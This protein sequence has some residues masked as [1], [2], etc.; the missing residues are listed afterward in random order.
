MTRIR[1]GIVGIGKI[2]R[3]QHIPSLHG[4]DAFEL[5]AG[6]SRLATVEG[7][8][9]FTT[10]EAML[11]GCP[12][13]DAVSICTPPQT[14]FE[15]ARLCLK[16]G[17]HV[18]LEKPP[19]TTTAQL[20]RLATL[21][22]EADR[23]L[24]Q[25]WHSRHAPGVEPAQHWLSSRKIRSV[26]VTWKEDVRQWH[27]GQTWIWEAGGFGVFDPGINAISILTKIIAEPILVAAADLFVPANCATPIAADIGFTIDGGAGIAAAFDFRHTGVQTCDIDIE[28][29]DGAL[30]LSAG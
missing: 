8:D 12:D 7:V 24:F 25:T 13:L 17:K 29:D 26:R 23:T 21:A 3:D 10:L 22:R 4:N 28:T 9:N 15:A 30:K 18:F 14:H 6:A 16:S 27:P 5:A 11:A 19:C 20:D 1:I 2:A